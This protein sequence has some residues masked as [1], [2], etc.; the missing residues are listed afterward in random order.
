[1][2]K[3]NIDNKLKEYEALLGLDINDIQPADVEDVGGN[4]DVNAL[5]QQIGYFTP[6]EAA[7]IP[8]IE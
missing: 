4:I 6:P 8:I 5:Q 2:N 7:P 1:M 3:Q